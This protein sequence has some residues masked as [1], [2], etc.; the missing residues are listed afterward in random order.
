MTQHGSR[1]S[2]L[3]GIGFAARPQHLPRSVWSL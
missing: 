3:E 2:G 1:G